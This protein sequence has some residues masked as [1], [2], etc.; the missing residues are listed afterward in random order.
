MTNHEAD[1]DLEVICCMACAKQLVEGDKVYN[2]K[3][4]GYI[5]ADC[6]GP[7]RESYYGEDE[8]PL[9][10]GEPIPDPWIWSAEDNTARPAISTS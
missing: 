2:E 6:C 10:D 3:E 8:Q 7:E 9:K 4:G 5:H 1:D